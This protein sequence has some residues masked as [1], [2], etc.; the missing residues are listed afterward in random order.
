M[1]R[2]LVARAAT[3]TRA[4]TVGLAALTAATV[5]LVFLAAAAVAAGPAVADEAPT[6]VGTYPGPLRFEAGDGGVLELGDG[7]RYLDTVELRFDPGGEV[8]LVNELSLDAYVTGVAEMP[9]R[10]PLEA[11]KAQAVAARTYAWHSMELGTFRNR[12]LGYDICPTVDC[13]VFRGRAVV[14]DAATGDRWQRAVEETAGEVLLTDDGGPILA[15]YF[16]TSGGRTVPNELVFPRNGPRPYLVGT[17]DPDDAVS[18][19]HRWTVTFTREQFDD[20]LGR[21]QTLGRAVPVASV[22]RDGQLEDPAATIVVTGRDGTQARV[23]AR[24]FREFVSRIAARHYPDD[25]PPL[26][27]D[28]L[29]PLPAT[30]PS[31]RFT[32][33]VR[34]DEVVVNGRGWGHGVGMGQYGAAGK[35][36]R[37]MSYDDI[38]AEYYNGLRPQTSPDVPERIRVGLSP[39]QPATVRG[40]VPFRILSGDEVVVERALGTWQ[41]ERHGSSFLLA[42]PPELDQPLQV[43]RT[44]VVAGLDDLGD[45]VTVQVVVNKPAELRL[46]VH[47]TDGREVLIRPLGVA[48]PGRHAA[49][50]SY[51]DSDGDEVP[52]GRYRVA[53]VAVD[54]TGQV[55]G[56]PLEVEVARSGPLRHA[57]ED[58]SETAGGTA[59]VAVVAALLAA[60]V[61]VL[62]GVAGFRRRPDS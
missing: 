11:L 27:A 37:G 48:D 13:Q 39:P 36:N 4:A 41:V 46:E 31:S 44:Q 50:W 29:R 5:G 32:V 8:L 22:D 61:V 57:L 54:E 58:W 51:Q 43:S 30:L 40:R 34:D 52:Q 62:V 18:P 16:S 24:D 25:F 28:G 23:T 26:R 38:L 10:W 17:E 2:A 21:G 3:L 14:E 49:T 15:R 59:A 12:G 47:G 33:D 42:G 53:L 7:R 45:A 9:T 55:A 19:L 20:I 35:A 6:P 1:R 56:E 60:A